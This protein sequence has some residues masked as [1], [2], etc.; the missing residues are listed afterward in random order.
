M[1]NLCEVLMEAGDQAHVRLIEAHPD[2]VGR[3]AREGRLT[4]ESTAEQAAA[5]LDAVSPAEAA[6]F[7]RYNA[8]YRQKFGFPFVICARQNK[9]EAIL[10]AF[11]VRLKHTRGDEI[12]EAIGEIMAIAWLRLTDAV[13]ED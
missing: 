9:K 11:P 7:D 1:S 13:S 4:R 3:L 5:G 2:L 12:L 6:A 10:A 8:A